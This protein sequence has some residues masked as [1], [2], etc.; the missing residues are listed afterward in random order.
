MK[1]ASHYTFTGPGRIVISRGA[2]RGAIGGYKIYRALAP[3]RDILGIEDQAEYRLRYRAEVLG[4]LDPRQTWDELHKL[5]AGAEPVI[6][7][8]ERPPFHAN[9]WCHR[10]MAAE[11]FL[12]TLGEV[13]DE[14]EP[15]TREQRQAILAAKLELKRVPPLADGTQPMIR[16]PLRPM[17]EAIRAEIDLFWKAVLVR[18]NVVRN[19][20]WMGAPDD[21]WDQLDVVEQAEWME[22]QERYRWVDATR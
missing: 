1:T 4:I 17:V 8:F 2:P 11:W 22:L 18:I 6:Q 19:W 9:N 13:V 7:C 12:E 16:T 15:E 5:A 20:S 3:T 10:R 21:V 14:L